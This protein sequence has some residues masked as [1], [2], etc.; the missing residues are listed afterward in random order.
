M[1]RGG[2][3]GAPPPST[4]AIVLRLGSSGPEVQALQKQLNDLGESVLATGQFGPRTLEAVRRFQTAKGI[5][6]ANGIVDANTRK[7]LT[8]LAAA[9]N[10]R[11][12]PRAARKADWFESGAQTVT[13][14][15]YSTPG[16]VMLMLDDGRSLTVEQAYDVMNN[17]FD[18][19]R[20]GMPRDVDDPR[21]VAVLV[22]HR[23]CAKLGGKGYFTVTER[24]QLG[25]SIK[26]AFEALGEAQ[27]LAVGADAKPAVRVL[28]E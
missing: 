16:S 22:A 11:T 2:G 8:E 12:I 21:D 23:E 25:M 7:A 13:E 19:A 6:P 1:H 17:A 28:E 3:R 24:K 4:T 27:I 14:G 9:G 26:A 18:K 20:G 15:G 10:P 5:Q